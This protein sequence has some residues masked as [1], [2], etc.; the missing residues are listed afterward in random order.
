M[1]FLESKYGE[2]TCLH[3]WRNT[4]HHHRSYFVVSLVIGSAGGMQSYDG[5]LSVY[6]IEN[7]LS[8]PRLSAE[9]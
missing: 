1:E 5:K 9:R 3:A 6:H 2:E 7:Q 8:Y 4:L